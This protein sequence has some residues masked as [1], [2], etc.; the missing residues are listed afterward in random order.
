MGDADHA[1]RRLLLLGLL[2]PCCG[3]LWDFHSSGDE[4]MSKRIRQKPKPSIKKSSFPRPRWE[5]EESDAD[6]GVDSLSLDLNSGVQMLPN[7]EDQED[8]HIRKRR[9]IRSE[10]P[11]QNMIRREHELD[12]IGL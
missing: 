9:V 11:V 1:L 8:W 3:D 4:A 7:Y 12:W 6:L 5:L 10:G 2:H